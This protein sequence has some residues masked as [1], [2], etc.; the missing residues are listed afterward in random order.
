MLVI[1]GW[2][3]CALTD[4]EFVASPLECDASKPPE[5]CGSPKSLWTPWLHLRILLYKDPH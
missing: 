1:C 2:G 4:M 3:R 5:L